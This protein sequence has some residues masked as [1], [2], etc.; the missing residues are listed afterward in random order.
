MEYMQTAIKCLGVGTITYLAYTLIDGLSTY[1]VPTKLHRYHHERPGSTWT[2]V[3]GGSDGI[4]RA[5]VDNLL[6][7]GFNVL[8][9]G[10]NETKLSR[11]QDELSAQYPHL[12]IRTVISDASS[13]QP[14]IIALTNAVASLPG[15]LTVL[16]NNVGG[17]PPGTD[18]S[19]VEAQS[20]TY[21]DALINMNLRFPTQVTRALLPVL[22][23]SSPA[24]IM[25]IGSVAGQLP[26]PYVT[27]YGA[28]KSFNNHFSAA[29]KAEMR[30]EGLADR[31]EVLG[32]LVSKVISASTRQ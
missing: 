25:N 4:G 24:L 3:T 7:Q 23:T 19:P 26:M 5:F 9:H 1:V 14:D 22:K 20:T 13:T 30:A 29:L 12:L 10:R 11:I 32:I 17:T 8:I 31:V 16:I 28:C 6:A 18:F 27:T 21:L 15:P 2:L